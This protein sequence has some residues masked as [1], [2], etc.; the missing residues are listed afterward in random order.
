[1]IH[2]FVKRVDQFDAA[3]EAIS[4]IGQALRERFSV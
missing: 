1:M 3:L 4:E 2:A